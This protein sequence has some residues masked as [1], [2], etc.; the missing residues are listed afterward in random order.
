[1]AQM[2]GPH[3]HPEQINETL[4]A[5]C[6]VAMGFGQVPLLKQHSLEITQVFILIVW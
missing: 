4:L 6:Y 2:L 3:S 1:M 5:P